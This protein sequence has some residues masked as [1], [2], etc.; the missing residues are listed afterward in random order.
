MMQLILGLEFVRK[1]CKCVGSQKAASHGDQMQRMKSLVGKVTS[2][3]CMILVY[4]GR[5]PRW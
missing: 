3:V 1:S 5:L 4:Y 2:G